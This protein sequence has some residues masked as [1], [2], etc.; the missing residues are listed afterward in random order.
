[1]NKD[2]NIVDFSKNK[3]QLEMK[4]GSSE[5]RANKIISAFAN[6]INVQ[7]MILDREKNDAVY[8]F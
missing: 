3:E 4:K 8:D 1:M 7:N 5:I 6:I 2:T